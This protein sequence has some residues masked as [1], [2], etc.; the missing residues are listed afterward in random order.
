MNTALPAAKLLL[1]LM[2]DMAVI[3]DCL[4]RMA[5]GLGEADDLPSNLDYVERQ[6]SF[7]QERCRMMQ[8]R[9]NDWKREYGEGGG[10]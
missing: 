8:D 6:L 7:M 3:Q 1:R 2:R 10:L 9:I 4:G 5:D